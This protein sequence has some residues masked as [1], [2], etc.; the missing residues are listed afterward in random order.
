M[1]GYEHAFMPLQGTTGMSRDLSLAAWGDEID[2][3]WHHMAATCAGQSI[4]EDSSGSGRVCVYIR[5]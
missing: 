2:G 3:D 1:D 5:A 4:N